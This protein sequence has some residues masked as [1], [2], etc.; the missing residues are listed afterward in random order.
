MSLN[1]ASIP[2]QAA[3]RH[4]E[5]P[6][7]LLG[8]EVISYTQ[9]ADQVRACAAALRE[10]DVVFGA[11]VALMMPNIPY[12]TIG[13]FGILYIGAAVVPLNVLL[14]EDEIAYHLQDSDANA[15]IV[16]EGFL[17]RALPGAK[18]AGCKSVFVARTPN[19]TAPL[20]AGT[21]DI[22]KAMTQAMQNN[23]AATIEIQSTTPEDTAVILYTSGT[24]GRPK[25]AELSHFNMYDNARFVSE[26]MMRERDDELTVL[27]LGNVALAALPLFH[28]FGQTVVQNGLLL[29]GAAVVFMPRFVPAEAAALINT[30]GV[31]LFAGV[32]A[33]YIGLLNDQAV[34]AEQLTTLKY[35]VSGGAPL[36]VDVLR[37]VEA[38]FHVPVLEGYGLSETS[39]I[40]CFNNLMRPRKP[41]TVGPAIDLCEVR[42]ADDVGT[43]LPAGERGEILIRGTNVM[44]SYYKRAE[45][46]R[47]VLHGGWFR[48]GDI[49]FLDQDGYIVIVDRK[50]EMIN[51]SGFKIYPRE[52]EEVLYAHPDIQEA[53]VFGVPDALHG[54]E[55]VSAIAL[56]VGA[57]LAHAELEQ[58]CR[59]HLAPY[60][61][62]RKTYF[63]LA[64]PKG[65]TGKILKL[66]IKQE[67]ISKRK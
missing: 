26:R 48:T 18:K 59:L 3:K 53:A 2:L 52:V 25:G 20:P 64:L 51:R 47:E 22:A 14:V 54:E 61:V 6:A 13:Y 42:I 16:W 45:A 28:S 43:M 57:T 37:A 65:S 31:T 7:L 39:P 1:L 46:T 21:L 63:M 67:L 4:P 24:T 41:G 56:K 19:I 32:P 29:N 33:M 10:H 38:R 17:E 8:D 62:P 66:I 27:G 5:A 36:P 35:M 34:K 55:V 11:H 9:L 15:L 49:G 50:K 12:F 23:A 58:Y 60:K 40:V 44:K 30:H